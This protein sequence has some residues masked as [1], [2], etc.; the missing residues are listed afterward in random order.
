MRT[1]PTRTLLGPTTS[2]SRPDHASVTT[3]V[4]LVGRPDPADLARVL[5]RHT[6]L[7][8]R[9]GRQLGMTTTWATTRWVAGQD[10]GTV[11]PSFQIAVPG[12]RPDRAVGEVVIRTLG[13]HGWAGR[14][15][16]DRE[17]FRVDAR[18]PGAELRLTAHDRRIHL[19]VLGAP[20]D[21][22]HDE[23]RLVLAGVYEDEI[24]A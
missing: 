18:R 20:L 14:L 9:I 10:R 13:R 12:E 7:G 17:T 11:L 1:Q 16:A 3:G 8:R 5:H 6:A 23:A 19:T 15:I 21:L 2:G 4:S 24:A 22:G